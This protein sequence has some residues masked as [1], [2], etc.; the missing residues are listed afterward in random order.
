MINEIVIP[1][2]L[3]CTF[4]P[5]LNEEIGICVIWDELLEKKSEGWYEK[6][7]KCRSKT[8]IEIIYE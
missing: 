4:C 5:F 6:V 8:K 1:D 7:E 2:S 3:E